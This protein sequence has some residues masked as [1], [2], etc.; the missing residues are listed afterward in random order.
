MALNQGDRWSVFYRNPMDMER[1]FRA[2]FETPRNSLETGTRHIALS[3]TQ[4]FSPIDF[5][6]PLP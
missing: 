2:V 6:S 5:A 3:S 1:E 4:R